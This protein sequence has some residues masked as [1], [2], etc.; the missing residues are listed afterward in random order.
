MVNELKA[1]CAEK[2]RVTPACLAAMARNALNRTP[3]LGFFRTFVMET[4]GKQKQII[5]LKGRGTAPLTDLIRIHA[6]ACGT[7]AQNSFDRLEAIST[8]KLVQPQALEPLRYALEFLSMVRIRNPVDA[9]N[10]GQKQIG[11]AE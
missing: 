9:I 1:L 3:P 5:N 10:Q 6:L 4:D 8:T 2:S 7:T 11:R